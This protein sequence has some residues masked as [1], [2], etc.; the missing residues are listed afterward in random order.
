MTPAS[1]T[2][3]QFVGRVLPWR[4][5]SAL[6]VLLAV[7]GFLS[8]GWIRDW[9]E[10][11]EALQL[12]EERQFNAALP[13]LL[14]INDMHPDN[15]AV[16]RAL[17][18]GYLHN[19]RQIPE[20]RKFL[21]RWCEMRPD[22]PEPFR[23]RLRFWLIQEMVDPAISD[24]EHVL[25]LRP[26][27]AETRE[28]LVQLLLTA[29]R[30]QEAEKEGL[31]SFQ[32]NPKNIGL[33]YVL[34]NIYRGLGQ[35]ADGAVARAKAADLTDQ[36]LRV[37]PDHMGALKLRAKLYLDAEK[38][39]EAIHLLRERVV[40]TSGPDETLGLYELG[41]AL[42][43]AGRAVEAKKVFAELEWRQTL[44]LWNKHEYR[45]SNF[46][47]QTRVVEAMLA[48]DKVDDAVKFLAGALAQNPKAP[49]AMHRLLATCYEKQGKTELALEERRQAQLAPDADQVKK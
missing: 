18:L 19:T 23:Q 5:L 14:H 47:L 37:Q 36:V 3:P 21:D 10:L 7:A 46:G 41:E 39:E 40:G 11:R 17:A 38:P 15:V 24:A 9:W 27:D 20:T 2:P 8:R 49:A 25:K 42:T 43:R 31:R 33:W 16:T 30:Y 6:I 28:G 48:A 13:H 32:D 1:E 35:G 26:N 12:A 34:A 44:G 22:D 29:G 4:I 45:D